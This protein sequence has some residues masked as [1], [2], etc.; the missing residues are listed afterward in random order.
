MAQD[1][2]NDLY[3]QI[4]TYISQHGPS[5]TIDIASAI[6][7]DTMQTGA[8][9]DYFVARGTLQRTNRKYGFSSVYFL[10]DQ[11][12]AA[13][14]KL[15][16]TLSNAEKAIVNK[17]KEEK[18]IKSD[19]LLPAERYMIQNLS[20]FVRKLSAIDRDTNEKKD[21]FVYYNV[22]NETVQSIINKEE[23]P[24]QTAAKSQK[25]RTQ[26]ISS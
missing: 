4:K 3:A 21:I 15:Y 5:L 13:L 1:D 14:S 6:G 18:A 7:K 19:D 12:D 16:E 20:D 22:P 9:L 17:F 11:K 24:I 25:G 26:K 8:I 2:I 23:K 10:P